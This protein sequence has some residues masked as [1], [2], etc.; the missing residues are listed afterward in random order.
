MSVKVIVDGKCAPRG[1]S[2]GRAGGSQGGFTLIELLV[3]MI[4]AAVLLAIV[5]PGLASFVSSSRLRASQ[6][7]FVAALT[8]ARS[9]ATKRGGDVVVKA[10]GTVDGS[11]FLGGWQVFADTDGDGNL[12]AGETLIREYAALT[13]Q[14]RFAAVEGDTT[15]KATS[16]AFNSRGFLKG[17]KL[18]FTLCGP[19]GATKGYT[20]RLEQVG[21]ADVVEGESCT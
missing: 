19:S 20:I 4:V 21:I 3:T 12:D 1:G 18:K 2:G 7:E 9:E 8:L 14:M 16:T 11:E 10:L 13:G 6:S 15:T 5:V 17:P